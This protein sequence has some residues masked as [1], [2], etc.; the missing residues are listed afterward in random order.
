MAI[1][2]YNSLTK[3]A[4]PFVPLNA[5]EV[6]MY[7]CG[8]TIYNYSHI[9]NF[10]AFVFYDLLVRY[11]R[12]RGFDVTHV[13]NLTDVDD[14]TIKGSM[15]K[16]QSLTDYTSFYEKEFL[17][18]MQTLN[19]NRPNIIPKATEEID[20][21]VELISKLLEKGHAY[22][23]DKGDIYFKI[24]SFPEYGEMADIDKRSLKEN[25]DNRLN[26]ADEYG[27]DNVFDFALWKAWDEND[28]DVYWETKIG[29][30]RPGWHIE[31]S[32]MSAKYLGQ[33][34]DIHTGGIDLI[35]PHHTNEIAQS[36]CACG[37]KFCNYWMH[38]GHLFVNGKKMSKSLGNFYTLRDLLDKGYSA[39]AIRY[40]L[41]KGHYRQ[42][43]DFKEDNLE[44]NA[45][46]IKKFKDFLSRLDD[47]K[48]ASGTDDAQALLAETKEAFILAMDEDLN[49]P[50]GLAVLFDFM[51]EVNKRM[52]EMSAKGAEGVKALF[53]SFMDVFGFAVASKEDAL[54]AEEEAL[55]TQRNAA[56]AEKN[57]ALADELKQ[58]LK[59]L[60][61]EVKDTADGSKWSR[62]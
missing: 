61:I 48:D 33:P 13:M 62:I 47:V 36:E 11:L 44:A 52:P 9:G 8:P 32:A 49:T 31:C 14:K 43:L 2:F 28:G 41:I 54:N 16:G 21:M 39:E 10:R 17:K 1:T 24:S 18:D 34:F 22:K 20:A 23:N 59:A 38:N 35:F 5:G 60:G 4:E 51:G 56:R 30:G 25:A 26:S 50:N 6:K 57:Y 45:K 55:F 58:K 40:E 42:E 37:V 27:K 15:A 19:M 3:K 53:N 12:F 7:S 29:K 46:V